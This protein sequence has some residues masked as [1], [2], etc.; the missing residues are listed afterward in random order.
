MQIDVEEIV[1]AV[2]ELPSVCLISCM[3]KICNRWMVGRCTYYQEVHFPTNLAAALLHEGY[4]LIPLTIQISFFQPGPVLVCYKCFLLW[5]LALS[6]STLKLL[7]NLQVFLSDYPE[8]GSCCPVSNFES[9]QWTGS[10]IPS[11]ESFHSKV[12]LESFT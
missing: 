3:F 6:L 7:T 10:F 5:Q 8:F 4:F 12:S 2:V 1:A 9:G 11:L